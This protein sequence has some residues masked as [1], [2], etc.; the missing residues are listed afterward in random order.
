MLAKREA[1]K[2][3]PTD[4]RKTVPWCAGEDAIFHCPC[5]PSCAFYGYKPTCWG[6]WPASG[7]AWRDMHC[8][9]RHH[10]AVIT[11]LTNQNPELI[12]L[13]EVQPIPSVPLEPT[14]P[15]EDSADWSAAESTEVDGQAEPE[16]TDVV[17]PESYDEPEAHDEPEDVEEPAAVEDP[18]TV[19]DENLPNEDL[20]KPSFGPIR[21]PDIGPE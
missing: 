10:H 9:E 17:E 13:P 16:P 14:A 7:A 18:D 5:K 21:L 4:I 11:D 8:G 12:T 19:P 20:P 6:T 2:C 1:E 15:G 3:C